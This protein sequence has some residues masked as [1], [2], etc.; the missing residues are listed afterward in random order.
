MAERTLRSKTKDNF[1][2]ENKVVIEGELSYLTGYNRDDY[3]HDVI[4]MQILVNANRL[5]ML[6]TI[7]LKMGEKIIGHIS[8]IHNY[9]DHEPMILRKGASLA[10]KD[11]QLVIPLNMRDG[12]L[13]CK[14]KGNED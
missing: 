4:V 2:N 5:T 10:K 1:D 13:I 3:L 8:S 6:K 9:I 7:V 12:L 14:G 11:E